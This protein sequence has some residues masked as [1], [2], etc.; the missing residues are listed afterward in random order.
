[1]NTQSDNSINILSNNFYSYTNKRM[2]YLGN[3][4]K[5]VNT[6]IYISL[7]VLNAVT[8]RKCYKIAKQSTASAFTWKS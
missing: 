5:T 8:S 7:N 1:M 6:T 3:N 2:S 4:K